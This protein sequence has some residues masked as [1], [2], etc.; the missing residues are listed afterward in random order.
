MLLSEGVAPLDAVASEIGKLHSVET[1]EYGPGERLPLERL[2]RLHVYVRDGAI[3]LRLAAGRATPAILEIFGP[4]RFLSPGL[5]QGVADADSRHAAALVRTTTLELPHDALDRQLTSQPRLAALLARCDVEQHRAALDRLAMLA[6][7]EPFRRVAQALL[8]L[9][10]RMP[11]STDSD[12]AGSVRLAGGQELI[13]AFAGL[14]RQTTNR[15]LRRL[16]RAGVVGLRRQVVEIR[17]PAAL[18]SAAAGR[19]PVSR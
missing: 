4:D 7:S 15:Q 3:A 19:R 14:S 17:D 13:A 8:L 5:W 12:S 16:A 1:R 6:L 2:K 11:R 10:E 9:H 18:A